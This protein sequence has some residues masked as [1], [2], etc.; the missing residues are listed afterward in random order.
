MKY[1][2]NPYSLGRA[3]C[4]ESEVFEHRFFDPQDIPADL[5]APDAMAITDWAK[6]KMEVVVE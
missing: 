5:F 6:G 4:D 3:E 2:S 1:P